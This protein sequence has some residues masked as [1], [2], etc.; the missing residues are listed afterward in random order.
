MRIEL[1]KESNYFFPCTN[2]RHELEG[3]NPDLYQIER[4]EDSG[5]I[6]VEAYAAEVGSLRSRD[7][8]VADYK[9][10]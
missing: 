8:T 9:E 6:W 1:I 2:Q 5:E 7:H 4:S 10:P 3:R